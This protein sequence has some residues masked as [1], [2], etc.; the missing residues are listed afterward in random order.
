[1]LLALAGAQKVAR[2]TTTVGALRE[3]GWPSS[4]ALVRLLGAAELAAAIVAVPGWP[5]A[6]A[7]VALL[8]AGFAVFVAA[9][10]HRHTPLRSCGCLGGDDVPP[11]AIHLTVDATATVVAAIVAVRGLDVLEIATERAAGVPFLALVVVT[12]YLLYV[13]LTVLPVVAFA[14]SGRA[15]AR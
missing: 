2:P 7:A 8:Y 14:P 12:T 3:A 5:A 1:V 9:A 4:P 10:L 6:A 11:T 13:V 15:L